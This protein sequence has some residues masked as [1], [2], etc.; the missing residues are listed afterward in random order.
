MILRMAPGA[1]ARAVQR[2]GPSVQSAEQEP[3]RFPTTTTRA[4]YSIATDRCRAARMTI[5]AAICRLMR[6][7]E[8]A[9]AGDDRIARKCRGSV[10]RGR[11]VRRHRLADLRQRARQGIGA[12][13]NQRAR[14]QDGIAG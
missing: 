10:A 3:P 11:E 5:S 8:R 4:H 1:Q 2:F 7:S 12:G 9:A 14:A 6:R 13:D